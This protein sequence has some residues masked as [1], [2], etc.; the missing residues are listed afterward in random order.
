M[1]MNKLDSSAADY[2]QKWKELADKI[3]ENNRT[4]R[5]I[6]EALSRFNEPRILQ[7]KRK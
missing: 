3:K 2:N 4:I 7:Y 5:A 6:S 1:E